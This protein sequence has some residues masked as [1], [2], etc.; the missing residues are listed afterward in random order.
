MKKRSV[1]YLVSTAVVAAAGILPVHGAGVTTQ[2]LENIYALSKTVTG[3]RLR[4]HMHYVQ[5]VGP[6]EGALK[7][8]QIEVHMCRFVGMSANDWTLPEER[9]LG[10]R[11]VDLYIDGPRWARYETRWNTR[12]TD[13]NRCMHVVVKQTTADMFDGHY[14]YNVYPDGK[15][16]KSDELAR[17]RR[18]V[19]SA[20]FARQVLGGAAVQ[21]PAFAERVTGALSGEMK[22]LQRMAQGM[23]AVVR[24]SALGTR[25]VQ[26]QLCNLSRLD[27]EKQTLKQCEWADGKRMGLKEPLVL[28]EDSVLR[29][30]PLA[31]NAYSHLYGEAKLFD[32]HW[33]PDERVF[34]PS[35]AV[36]GR[37]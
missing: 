25:R 26:G 37:P 20:Q 27:G 14:L 3:S 7:L 33:T 1:F 9:D 8:D 16:T 12:Y 31:F 30:P 18:A 10:R 24:H 11:I 5:H 32:V 35:H 28:W 23:P 6:A 22:H 29:K 34:R 17:R 2:Q 19:M 15:V 4:L 21:D 36:G 13:K